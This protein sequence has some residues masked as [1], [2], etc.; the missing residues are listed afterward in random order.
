MG[1]CTSTDD[2]GAASADGNMMNKDDVEA[3]R[4]LRPR[5]LLLGAGGVGKS[6]IVKQLKISFGDGFHSTRR[7]SKQAVYKNVL[8]GLQALVNELPTHK[9]VER[10]SRAALPHPH[11]TATCQFQ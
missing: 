3:Q 5:I 10:P 4:K 11:D 7:E 9:L 6:T 1:A 8:H 2:K